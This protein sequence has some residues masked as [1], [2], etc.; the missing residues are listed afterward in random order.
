MSQDDGRALRRRHM[1]ERQAVVF[2]VLLAC[3]A[4]AGL[5]SAA[6]YT[7]ALSLPFLD[8]PFSAEP[9]EDAAATK[10][11]CPPEGA[12]PVPPDQITV[13]VYN[14]TKIAGFGSRTKEALADFG[15]VVG[16]VDNTD[17][18]APGVGRI[19]YGVQG[20]AAAYTLYSYAPGATL[21]LDGRQDAVVDIV[22]GADFALVPD[23]TQ[24][25][26]D[27]AVPLVGPEACIPLA[28]ATPAAEP[29]A[30]DPAAEQPAEV[31]F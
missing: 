11:Y 21:V 20:S 3:L 18:E 14:S 19:I 10:V 30:A 26:L 6:M 7:G 25:G 16:T 12:L 2:G 13:D 22:L 23:D 27:P 4:V 5:G 31:F 28:E 8:R 24:V 15:F 17:A 29:P 1:H 9:T